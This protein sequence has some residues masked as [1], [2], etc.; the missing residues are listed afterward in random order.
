MRLPNFYF[1]KLENALEK[2]ILKV[3]IVDN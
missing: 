2:I 3:A 1:K